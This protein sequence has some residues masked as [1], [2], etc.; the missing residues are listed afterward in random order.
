M[1]NDENAKQ[2]IL[3]A[4]QYLLQQIFLNKNLPISD[5]LNLSRIVKL[6]CDEFLFLV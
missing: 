3:T 2:N 6:S 5:I 4:Q 1:Q